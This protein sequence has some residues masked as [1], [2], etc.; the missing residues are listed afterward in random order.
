MLNSRRRPSASSD[1]SYFPGIM[2]ISITTVILIAFIVKKQWIK[3]GFWG[4][5]P[6][7][8]VVTAGE[9]GTFLR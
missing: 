7:G 2:A 9:H 4:L 1:F 3:G 8:A 6:A 5:V